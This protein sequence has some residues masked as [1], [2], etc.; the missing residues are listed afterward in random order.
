MQGQDELMVFL[1]RRAKEARKVFHQEDR[2]QDR[3]GQT[4]SS[5][6]LFD[7][8]F[9]FKARNATRSL[10]A[11]DRAIDEMLDLSCSGCVRQ[12]CALD[13]LAPDA[14]PSCGG[15]NAEDAIHPS[16]RF[17]ERCGREQVPCDQLDAVVG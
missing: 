5:D 14:M 7:L 15:L 10:S 8:P 9:A 6:M 3:C 11:A 17:C 1:D 12:S 4:K 13:D 16:E 2:T